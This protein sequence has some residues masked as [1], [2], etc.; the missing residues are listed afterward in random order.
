MAFSDWKERLSSFGT[1][2]DSSIEM[3]FLDHLEELR[4]RII[5]SLLAVA[6]GV[7]AGWFLVTRFNVLGLLVEPIEPIVQGGRLGYLSPMDPF[8]ITLRLALIVGV[9]LALPI[10]ARQFWSFFSPALTPSEK[11]AIIPA[12]YFGLVLFVAGVLLA[13][14][15][16][17]PMMFRFA[18]QFQTETLYQTIVIG[19][20]ISIVVRTLLVFGIFFE[21]PIVI[22]VLSV[23]G[24]VD[25]GA[26]RKGRRWAVVSITIAAAVLTPGD[27]VILTV[28]L[29][30]PLLLLYEL[31]ILLAR[32]VEKR[33]EERLEELR[34][35]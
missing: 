31:G 30:V 33:R 22:L 19:P 23:V 29:M 2:G 4:W 9:L 17:L 20:Y 25:S 14:F 1:G 26:L 7:V 5:W 8:F 18:A 6:L 27:Y 28:F 21:L 10:V 15:V 34:E 11:R 24:I 35:W 3:P 16:A 13:Y 12:L 32:G